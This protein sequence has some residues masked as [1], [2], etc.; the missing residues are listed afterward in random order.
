MYLANRAELKSVGDLKQRI[1][2]NRGGRSNLLMLYSPINL[3]HN[4]NK[5][6]I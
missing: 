2:I 3:Y 6:E 4:K 5:H 1:F